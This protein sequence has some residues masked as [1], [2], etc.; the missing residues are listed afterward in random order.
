LIAAP[1]SRNA[2]QS[3]TSA[4]LAARLARIVLVALPTLR[5]I[6]VSASSLRAA[7]GK[8]VLLT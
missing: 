3:G 7:A 8:P 2:S 1:A 6:C 4:T 5:R